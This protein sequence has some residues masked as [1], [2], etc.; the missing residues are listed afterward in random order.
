MSCDICDSFYQQETDQKRFSMHTVYNGFKFLLQLSPVS[1]SSLTNLIPTP[2]Y[3][4]IHLIR[5]LIL[6]LLVFLCMRF[7]DERGEF[8]HVE[9]ITCHRIAGS[10]SSGSWY[11]S[12]L[13]LHCGHDGH[14]LRNCSDLTSFNTVWTCRWRLALAWLILC[15]A[16][17]LAGITPSAPVKQDLLVQRAERRW[18]YLENISRS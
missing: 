12:T 11:K 15:D 9:E 1:V 10:E 8:F 3:C 14:G 16:H 18:H 2:T 5:L 4:N 13:Y 17:M 7:F 6:F